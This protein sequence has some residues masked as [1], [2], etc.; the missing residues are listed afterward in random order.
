MAVIILR[1]NFSQKYKSTTENSYIEFGKLCAE[2]F[3]DS[4]RRI[5]ERLSKHPLSSPKEPWLKDI[6][7]YSYRSANIM[8]NW[9]IIY[10]YEEKTDTVYF[11]DL[12][13]MRRNPKTLV[14]IF[15]QTR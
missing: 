9:K 6:V 1:K 11:V 3:D 2:R 12:W 8:K 14:R 10:R 13:D 5:I 4:L 15:K 7:H